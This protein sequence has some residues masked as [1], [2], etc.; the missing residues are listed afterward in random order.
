MTWAAPTGSNVAGFEHYKEWM[1]KGLERV[2]DVGPVLGLLHPLVADNIAL[3]KSIS[4]FDGVSFHMSGTEAAMAAVRLARFNTRRKLIVAFSGAYHGWWDGVQPGLGSKR[5]ISACLT[6]RDVH[7]ASL[8]VIRRHAG[9]IADVLINPA[10][11]FHPNTPPPSDAVLLTSTVRQTQDLTSDYASCAKCA[12]SAT[13]R[14][15]STKVCSGFRLAP[16]GAQAYFGVQADM[17][18]GGISIGVVCG[19]RKASCM[20][21]HRP[22]PIF[23]A[24]TSY[25][26]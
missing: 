8:D 24:M 5:A 4:G 15:S 26:F 2:K 25:A 3:L 16:G 17:V 19:G 14:Y 18:A 6:L 23:I 7:P 9:E 13:Y 10:Q 1:R 21:V 11:S 12:G 20:N 22:Q